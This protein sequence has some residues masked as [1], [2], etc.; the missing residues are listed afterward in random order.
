LG[1]S[2]ISSL[3]NGLHDEH[4]GHDGIAREMSAKEFFIGGDILDGDNVLAPLQ[5][6]HAVNHKK[7]IAVRKN[8]LDGHAVKRHV[9]QHFR[10]KCGVRTVVFAHGWIP[11]KYN[12]QC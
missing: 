4:A 9:F 10:R 12:S 3:G 5:L 7:G 8:F 1:T 6:D 2:V 11:K